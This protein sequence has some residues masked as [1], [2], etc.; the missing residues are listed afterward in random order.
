[1]L[2]RSC[3]IVVCLALLTPTVA[4]AA[5]EHLAGLTLIVVDAPDIAALHR[6]RALVQENGG[7]VGVMVP[8]SILIG[9][10]DPATANTLAGR[11]GIR[12]IRWSEADPARYHASDE[13]SLS[14][15]ESF[16]AVVSGAYAR[17]KR[18]EIVEQAAA[19]A[20]QPRVSDAFPR[21]ASNPSDVLDN[22]RAAGFDEPTL[23][24]RGLLPRDAQDGSASLTYADK[25]AGT[26]AV[27]FF[28]VESDGTGSDP[29]SWT[30][31]PEDMQE[32]MDDTV[33]GLLWWSNRADDHLDCWVTFLIN[34]VS[35]FDPRCHQWVEPSLHDNGFVTTWAAN[36]MT[37]MGY[38]S[39]NHFSKVDAFNA[40]QEA[41]YQAN[42]AYSAF[43][44]YNPI[45]APS[46]FA[47]GGYAFAWIYG[48]YFW[49]LFRT[50]G[51]T[52]DVVVSHETGHIFG[53]CDEYTGGC[54]SCNSTCSA[55]GG[56]NENCEDCNP[57]SRP[58]MMRSNENGLCQ[59]TKTMIGWDASSPCAPPPP[60]PLPTPT[61]ALVSPDD[62]LV[63]T[64]VTLTLTGSNFVAGVQVDLG[65]DVF[66]HATTL[67]NSTTLQ[68]W[69]SVFNDAAPGPVDV[70]VRNRDGQTAVLAGAFELLPTRRH[71]FSPSGGNVFPF[72]TPGDAGVALADVMAAAS[73]GDT[74]LVPT[75]TFSGFSLSIAKGITLQGAWNASFTARN[76]ATGKTAIDLDGI[77]DFYPSSDGAG[78]DGFLLENG[79]G[80]ADFFPAVARYA[81]SVRVFQSTI[82]IRNCEIR[83]GTTGPSDQ[84]G[85]GGAIYGYQSSVT[86]ENCHVHGN[87]AT[88]GG[89]VYLEQCSG[90][91]SGSAFEYNAVLTTGL[92]QPEGSCVY[93]AA[94][95]NVALT[96]NTI[97]HHSGG[98]NGGG[99]LVEN[100]TD[101]VVEGGVIEYNSASF[102]GGGIA[103]K[104]TSGTLRR[105]V[106]RRNT[107]LFAGGVMLTGAGARDVAECRIEWNSAM[108]GGGLSADGTLSL[109]HNLFVGNSATNLS[110]A[111][112]ISNV[113]SGVVAGNTFDRN[114][115]GSGA[116]GINLSSVTVP[117]FNNIVTNTTGTGIACAGAAPSLFDFN[118]VWNA[119]GGSYSGCTPGA[120]SISAD[121][122]FVDTTLVDYHLG[123]H[124]PCIDRGRTGAS[125]NDPDGSRGD[126][127]WYGSHAFTM[128]QP[129][130][131]ENASVGWS[132]T[133]RILNWD[134]SPEAD[135]A[136]YA[137]Y[138]DAASGFVPGAA[139]LVAIVAAPATSYLVGP[140]ASDTYFKVNAI[141][142]D[143]YAGGYSV[144]AS[145]QPSTGSGPTSYRTRLFQN[146]PNPFNPETEIR[147]ELAVPSNVSITVFDAAGR[148]VRVLEN[149]NRPAGEHTVRWNGRND[150][151]GPVSS[152][153]YFYRMSATGFDQ[154]RKMVLLK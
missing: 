15:I 143:G 132:G 81:G 93:I 112:G 83:N 73:D 12:D 29:D 84:L 39:G 92:N 144:E 146:H 96:D 133:D 82:A 154:T 87:S 48:P 72:I 60:A 109:T 54:S 62:G 123:L 27:T 49:S 118:N 145:A 94:S 6:A 110:G 63:G 53:A 76:L 4:P 68:V 119:S 152:G 116:G 45:G 65:A 41:T 22:L 99:I 30:W 23:A 130:F 43:I 69:A 34:H 111:L 1:M 47:N 58:C 128:D 21:E 131:V 97:D 7:R 108:F 51:W 95:S 120:G 31:T 8:P 66:V 127:G 98:Q 121:P 10:V 148:L 64:Q 52:H 14:A 124:S 86:I 137:V 28:L 37:K 3:L 24:E 85:Y 106:V 129:A 135:V 113:A 36:V 141:D 26:V 107:G 90:S 57:L 33:V 20:T 100:S 150:A 71:Y 78:I 46:S 147:F 89:A 153:V 35:A 13:Q 79:D 25:M 136:Q 55:Y 74:V 11:E 117:V 17:R 139:N 151:G 5:D 142:D 42:S 44:A 140:I 32:Y 114:S 70:V 19:S 56:N 91:I 122:L 61:L 125:F 126:M 101:V 80:R 67:T 103:F 59:Y 40:W 105:V 138:A 115:V 9:W 75:M 18:A 102:G 38:V 149:G 77:V 16:N 134:G 88:K 50:P 2:K 104:A